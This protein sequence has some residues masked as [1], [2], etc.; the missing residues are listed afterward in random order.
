MLV[1]AM[2][3][4]KAAKEKRKDMGAGSVIEI[5]LIEVKEGFTKKMAIE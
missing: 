2:E 3:K 4:N 1:S 5:L